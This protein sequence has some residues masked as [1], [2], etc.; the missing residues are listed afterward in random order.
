[1]FQMAG[2]AIK[3]RIP[4]GLWRSLRV[5]RFEI[6][7]MRLHRIGVSR[8]RRYV[9]VS[10]LK[11]NIGCGPN[12][13]EGWVNIDLARGADLPLDMRRPIPLSDAAAALIYSEHFLEHLDYP[14][15]TV[16]FLTESFR[17]L[18]PKGIFS[19]GVPDTEWALRE[20][21]GLGYGDYPAGQW[22]RGAKSG[23]HPAWCATRL[24]HINYHFRQYTQHRFAWDFE[25][26]ERA[27]SYVGFV[28]I[29]RRAFDPSLDTE[30]RAIGTLYVEAERP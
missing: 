4:R 24:E 14:G 29:K 23:I 5:L 10:S 7:A 1:M 8:A 20:Y 17:V 12:R 27:L 6:G 11:L 22:L 3:A 30:K 13:K 28:R 26:M 21:N 25:T 16:R 2:S 15:D 18:G 9:G 19:V